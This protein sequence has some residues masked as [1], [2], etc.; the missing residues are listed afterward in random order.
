M[1]HTI[2]K[3]QM[4]LKEAKDMYEKEKLD[5][6]HTTIAYKR[7]LKRIEQER[8]QMDSVSPLL[9]TPQM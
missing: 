6:E 2:K 4:Q 9:A 7:F 5:K 3:L 1:E 8:M